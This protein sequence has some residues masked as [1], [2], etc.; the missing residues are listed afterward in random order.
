MARS[1]TPFPKAAYTYFT[2]EDY[3]A[4]VAVARQD[5][6]SLASYIRHLVVDHIRRQTDAHQQ[7]QARAGDTR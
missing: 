3:A 6:R 5:R 1:T 4:L 2:D 7:D